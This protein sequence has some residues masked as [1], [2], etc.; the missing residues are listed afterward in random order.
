M[1]TALA[2]VKARCGVNNR[3]FNLWNS[4]SGTILNRPHRIKAMSLGARRKS[5]TTAPGSFMKQPLTPPHSEQKPKT[6][7]QQII[8]EIERRESGH[9]S[10]MNP[11]LWYT[12][13]RAGYR[14]LE[15]W[16]LTD[17]FVQDTPE[18]ENRA[19]RPLSRTEAVCR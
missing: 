16:L 17:S 3:D 14:A 9:S 13:S 6:S 1:P 4:I 19:S 7:E 11:W 10:S 2:K 12:L 15:P 8:E 5:D 18:K